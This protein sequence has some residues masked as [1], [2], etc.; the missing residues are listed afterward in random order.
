MNL[1]GYS[2]LDVKTGVY[3]IPWFFNHD[4]VALRAVLEIATDLKTTVG[5]YPE[6]YVLLCV[7]EYDDGTG[8]LR[9]LVPRQLGNVAAL[10]AARTNGG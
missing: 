10:R 3:S 2:L 7:G 9:A 8:E 1:R 5:K 6:D 4:E